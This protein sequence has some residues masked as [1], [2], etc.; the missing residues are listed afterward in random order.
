MVTLAV[1][2][3]RIAASAVGSETATSNWT[4]LFTTVLLVATEVTAPC[5][6][7]CRTPGS[8]TDT[9]WPGLTLTMSASATDAVTCFAWSFDQRHQAADPADPVPAALL[10]AAA[11]VPAVPLVVPPPLALSAVEDDCPTTAEMSATVPSTGARTVVS[12]TA[13]SACVDCDLGVVDLGLRRVDGTLAGRAAGWRPAGPSGRPG[14]LRRWRP[15]PPGSRS[16]A[17]PAS[18]VLS[19]VC[20]AWVSPAPGGVDGGLVG[21]DGGLQLGDRGL[22]LGDRGGVTGRLGGGQRLLGLG[23]G[24]LVVGLL[25][26]GGSQRRRRRWRP[27][28]PAA[29]CRAGSWLWPGFSASSALSSEVWA[30][31]TAALSTARSSAERPWVAVVMLASAEARLPRAVSR[32]C[33]ADVSSI[34]TSLSPLSTRWPCFHVDL[35]DLARPGRVHRHGRSGLDVAGCGDGRGDRS[36]LH[37]HGG[38]GRGGLEPAL[39]TD[40]AVGHPDAD[41]GHAEYGVDDD[42]APL[43]RRRRVELEWTRVSMTSRM[44]SQDAR[45]TGER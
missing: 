38:P 11:A 44:T 30:L 45:T 33:W 26:L 5:Q 1:W 19:R 4:T 28:C 15:G 2:P 12:L 23:Q 6:C 31:R 24:V 27:A 43:H 9:A 34:F 7:R 17:R 39:L 3:S 35:G 18:N 37:G 13:C 14:R 25:L 20:L 42:G 36:A 32:S 8:V 41:Q 16:P 21:D 10:P 29:S 22:L 40:T